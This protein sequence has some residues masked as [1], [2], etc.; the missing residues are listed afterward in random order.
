MNTFEYILYGP[1]DLDIL[2]IS[3]KAEDIKEDEFRYHWSIMSKFEKYCWY[4]DKV[5]SFVLDKMKGKSNFRIYKHEELFNNKEVFFDMLKFASQFDDGFKT[6]FSYKEKFMK[7]VHSNA[8]KRSFEAWE[9]WDS[10]MIEVFL[11][12][13]SKWMDEFNFGGEKAW[14]KK[15]KVS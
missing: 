5:N 8:D 13:C 15:L 4:Y 1:L 11:T 10:D 2:N 6:S 3:I 7:K 14:E 12:H 9:E